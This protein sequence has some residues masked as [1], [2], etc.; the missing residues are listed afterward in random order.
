MATLN[1]SCQSFIN[2][3]SNTNNSTLK[4]I[5]KLFIKLG[6]FNNI[7]SKIKCMES[8]SRTSSSGSTKPY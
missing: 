1:I 4:L 2:Q 3:R 6:L 8:A 5:D 7:Y